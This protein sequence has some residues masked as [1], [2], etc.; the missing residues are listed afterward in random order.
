MSAAVSPFPYERA[1]AITN[2]FA[3]TFLNSVFRGTE[4]IHPDQVDG[5]EDLIYQVK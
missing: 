4:P 5:Q 3:T 1:Q 2:T